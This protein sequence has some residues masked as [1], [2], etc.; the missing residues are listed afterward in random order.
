M[1]IYDVIF[2]SFCYLGLHGNETDRL[3]PIKHNLALLLKYEKKTFNIN[4]MFE[5]KSS[6]DL[7]QLI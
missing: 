5:I 1:A 2:I 3:I 6:L 4:N 7:G